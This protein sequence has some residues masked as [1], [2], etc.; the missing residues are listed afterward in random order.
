MIQPCLTR[1]QRPR[2]QLCGL[3]TVTQ[4]DRVQLGITLTLWDYRLLCLSSPLSEEKYLS[5][6][7]FIS[8]NYGLWDPPC[9]HAFSCCFH[10]SHL[11]PHQTLPAPQAVFQDHSKCTIIFLVWT[12]CWCLKYTACNN[13]Y[14]TNFPK[15]CVV[16]PQTALSFL[17]GNLALFIFDYRMPLSPKKYSVQMQRLIQHLVHTFHVPKHRA[18]L[19]LQNHLI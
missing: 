8:Q 19:L 9:Q 18:K 13:H 10:H 5:V 15:K 11:S 14:T 4:S 1:L 2:Q 16:L 12:S 3:I 6:C 7:L 17:S